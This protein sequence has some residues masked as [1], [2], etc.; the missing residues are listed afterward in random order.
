LLDRALDTE[1]D[2]PYNRQTDS[3]GEFDGRRLTRGSYPS[4]AILLLDDPKVHPKVW[5]SV[6]VE[7]GLPGVAIVFIGLSRDGDKFA[8][9]R[10]AR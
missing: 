4:L 7:C 10:G 9:L 8:L 3:F 2:L 5:M 6:L 1:L